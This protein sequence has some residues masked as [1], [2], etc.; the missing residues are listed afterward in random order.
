MELGI[1]GLDSS[2]SVEFSRILNGEM[3]PYHIGGHRITAAYPGEI[4]KD[5]AMSRERMD[6][7]T[8]E[9]SADW[10][11]K[12]YSSIAEV[13]ERTDG[14]FLEQVDARKRLKQFREIVRF[15][16][17]VFVDKPFVLRV[18]EC[19]EMCK[20]AER[21]QVPVLST[22]PL[23]FAD[24]L[25]NALQKCEGHSIIGAD[26]F[27][28]M[29][30][31]D[32]QPGYFWYGVHMAD[33][34]YR[35]MGTSCKWV[36]AAH[37]EEHD[38]VTGRWKDGRI[39][40]IRGNRCGNGAFGGTIFY[41][42]GNVYFDVSRDARGY[43]ESLLEQIIGMFDTGNSPVTNREMEEVVRFLEAANESLESERAVTL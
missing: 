18:D 27:G 10:G 29:P 28:P 20:L 42:S 34:L 41:E 17:P 21:Y 35:T 25:T 38:V 15:G 43:Y 26:F 37:T 32:T 7:F 33:M 24:S 13:M 36:F 6:D 12:L 31:T 5:F 3:E 40:T 14:V 23:R 2:H 39:A 8:R 30:F 16:K 4:S 11:V 1:I 9:V 19:Q 22:S